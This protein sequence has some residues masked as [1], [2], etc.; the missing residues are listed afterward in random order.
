MRHGNLMGAISV[1]ENIQ[2]LIEHLGHHEDMLDTSLVNRYEGALDTFVG[3]HP[4][5]H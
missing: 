3:I 1:H 2:V 4:L 5:W